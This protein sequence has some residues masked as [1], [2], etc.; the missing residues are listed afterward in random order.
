MFYPLNKINSHSRIWIYQS[1]RRI[2]H[3]Q[4]TAIENQLISF[5]N[6]WTSHGNNIKSSFYIDHWFICLFADEEV[7]KVSGC[8]IDAS[9]SFVK[10]IGVKYGI[11]FFNRMNIAFLSEGETRVLSLSE[12]K[13]IINSKMIVYNNMIKYKYEF[14]SHWK[15]P[16]ETNWLKKYIK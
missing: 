8:G 15:V 6:N 7:L 10:S 11:D 9:I 16:I 5:C 12:F 1:D 13:K 3:N 2:K 14:D 4:I